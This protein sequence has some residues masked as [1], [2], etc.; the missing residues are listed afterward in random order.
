METIMQG[1]EPLFDALCAR[2]KKPIRTNIKDEVC[3]K[4]D[5]EISNEK[6]Q[7]LIKKCVK[8]AKY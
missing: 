2:C 6:N 7:E 8:E 5:E 3:N 4:C 1:N